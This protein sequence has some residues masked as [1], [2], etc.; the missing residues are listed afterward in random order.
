MDD[1]KER[2]QGLVH[3]SKCI[4]KSFRN[5]GQR[6]RLAESL[7]WKYALKKVM[8]EYTDLAGSLETKDE[9]KRAK[10]IRQ[11]IEVFEEELWSL[12]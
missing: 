2:D 7:E 6:S 8:S 11:A 12:S 1:E 3:I 10:K 4:A 5:F 9:R